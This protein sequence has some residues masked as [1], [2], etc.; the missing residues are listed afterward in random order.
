MAPFINVTIPDTTIGLGALST[1]VDEARKFGAQKILIITDENLIKVGILEPITSSLE[2][3]GLNFDIY[4]GCN[5]EPPVSI[6]EELTDKVRAGDYDL[7]IGVGGGSN[8]DTTK[9]VSILVHSGLKI[10]D[11]IGKIGMHIEGRILPKILVPTTSGTG[12]EWSGVV[13]VYDDNHENEY[14]VMTSGIL[15]EKVILDPELTKNLPAEITADSGFDALTHAIEAYTS[16]GANVFSDM[17]AS[18]AI[19][20]VSENLRHAYTKGSYDMN[21]RYN[22]SLAAALAMNSMATGGLGICHPLNEL[23]QTKTHISH[24]KALAVLL[25]SVMEFN[26][27]GNP[28]KFAKIA[29]LMGEDI[30]GLSLPEA[31]AKSVE[32]I[33][34]LIRDLDLPQRMGDVGITE[35]DLPGLAKEAYETR[36]FLFGGNTRDV[37]ESDL[38]YIFRLAL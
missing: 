28:D 12:A 13:I 36:S 15:A 31:A 3:A 11:V 29:E 26:M 21:A 7:L 4:D 9:A 18:T 33:K 30:T 27:S 35:A 23:I 20:L 25:P 24:G 6:I 38:V 16:R 1:V 22:M 10:W 19:K 37:N 17:M 32:A 8:M 34:K 5:P 14:M 2:K